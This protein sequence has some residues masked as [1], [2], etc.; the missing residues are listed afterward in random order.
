MSRY[1]LIVEFSVKMLCDHHELPDERL[2]KGSEKLYGVERWK[3]VINFSKICSPKTKAKIA[4]SRVVYAVK[5]IMGVVY[6]LIFCV[7]LVSVK[8]DH[9][10]FDQLPQ[11]KPISASLQNLVSVLSKRLDEMKNESRLV[12]FECKMIEREF[13]GLKD[14]V[15]MQSSC[16]A[17]KDGLELFDNAVNE[18]FEEVINGRDKLLALFNLTN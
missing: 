14:E 8:L 10:E 15:L 9:Q 2:E 16:M 7:I 6:M 17:L 13:L 5:A 18:L 3:D 12:L 11:L 1:R 4:N